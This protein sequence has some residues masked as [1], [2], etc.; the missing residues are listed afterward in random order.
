LSDQEV[1]ALVRIAKEDEFGMVE[2]WVV[3]LIGLLFSNIPVFQHS[4][5][6]ANDTQLE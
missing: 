2:S 4:N 1:S 5:Y 3:T 6:Q